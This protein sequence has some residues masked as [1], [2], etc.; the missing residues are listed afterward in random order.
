MTICHVL[1]CSIEEDITA[2][3]AQ[4]FHPTPLTTPLATTTQDNSN[5]G[6]EIIILAAQFRGRGLLCAADASSLNDDVSAAVEVNGVD[7]LTKEI[8]SNNNDEMGPIS[9]SAS[10]SSSNNNNKRLP[11]SKLPSTMMGLV[12]D[13]NTSVNNNTHNHNNYN[14]DPPMQPLTTIETFSHVYNWRHEH[15][16]TKIV[17][18]SRFGDNNSGRSEKEVGLNAVLGWCDL[19]HA[20]HDPIPLQ[21]E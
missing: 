21:Q 11:I 9:S 1:P 2:P 19:A 5:E 20:V 12:F 13:N 3:V 7:D 16:E 8:H 15:D 4:Y 14:K 18:E 6:D 10:P 17:R